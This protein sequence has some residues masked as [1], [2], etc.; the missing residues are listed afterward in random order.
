MECK[1]GK[2]ATKKITE[3]NFNLNKVNLSRENGLDIITIPKNTLLYKAGSWKK[4]KNVEEELNQTGINNWHAH[5]ISWFTSKKFALEYTKSEWAKKLNYSLALFKTTKDIKLLFLYSY[6]NLNK[7]YQH[8][9]K[10]IKKIKK[11]KK[12]KDNNLE[13]KT[14]ENIYFDNLMKLDVLKFT[15]GINTDFNTQVKLCKKWG[16]II[17]NELNK[18]ED[19]DYKV[20]NEFKK[21]FKDKKCKY[22]N[23][24]FRDENKS[25]V[26]N[27]N[28]LCT[29]GPRKQD[30][31]RI[32]FSTASDKVMVETIEYYLNVDG[33]G[34]PSIPS[35]YHKNGILIE[36]FALAIPRDCV[37]YIN[38]V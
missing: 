36:E 14:I 37:K 29:I 30:L 2:I 4:L 13:K 31:N 34:T 33:Y 21:R 11:A 26:Y 27:Y 16:D 8:L 7:I 23:I 22:N 9:E 17:G 18:N 24:Y 19:N 12:L 38:L 15:T 32:S 6:E 1:K 10:D 3:L 5:K 28:N 35:L 20:S 25:F